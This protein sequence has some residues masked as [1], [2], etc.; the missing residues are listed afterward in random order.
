[1]EAFDRTIML[2][3]QSLIF[4]FLPIC[5]VDRDRNASPIFLPFLADNVVCIEASSIDGEV[6]T[7]VF[8]V[9]IGLGILGLASDKLDIAL[10]L[11]NR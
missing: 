1:M 6:G 2:D 8:L 7:D 4:L 11:S 10:V 3:F 9:T 5:N